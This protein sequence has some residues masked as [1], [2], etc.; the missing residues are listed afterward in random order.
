MWCQIEACVLFSLVALK[1]FLAVGADLA[2][3]TSTAEALKV[4]A[5]VDLEWKSFILLLKLKVAVAKY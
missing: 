5:K 4:N 1:L 2:G 3:L